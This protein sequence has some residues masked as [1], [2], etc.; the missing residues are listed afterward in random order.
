M[1]MAPST[2]SPISNAGVLPFWAGLAGW[3]GES[4][5][6]RLAGALG[7]AEQ[8]GGTAGPVRRILQKPCDSVRE[9]LSVRSPLYGF[10]VL[11]IES[12]CCTYHMNLPCETIGNRL[13]KFA[14][15]RH[16]S[17]FSRRNWGRNRSGTRG[18]CTRVRE[19]LMAKSGP[20]SHLGMYWEVFAWR[21]QLARSAGR[22]GSD[23]QSRNPRAGARRS[24]YRLCVGHR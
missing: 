7:R 17:R 11:P 24:I 22:S 21:D 13:T 15:R 18:S 3:D 20:L 8:C 1:P 12:V 9:R 16:F 5:D 6:G 2:S 19:A 14:Y 10:I 4:S 23:F